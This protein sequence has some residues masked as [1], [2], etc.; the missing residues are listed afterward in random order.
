MEKR[1][2]QGYHAA[3]N[4]YGIFVSKPGRDV[5]DTSTN[6]LLD[7]RFRTLSVHAHGKTTM[8]K[9][10][11]SPTGVL[12]Y[13]EV[14][15]PDLGYKPLFFGNITYDSPNSLGLP[16]NSAG[17]PIPAC[18]TQGASSGIG[19]LTAGVWLANNATLRARAAVNTTSNSSTMSLYWIVFKN[20][21]E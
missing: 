4:D 8:T 1:I 11:V 20:R 19:I 7:S 2:A 9:V 18:G 13:A 12:W 15:F 21:F 3:V 17:I 5:D 6:F 14:T 16:V 10:N